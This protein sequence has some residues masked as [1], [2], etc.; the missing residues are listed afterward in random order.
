MAKQRTPDLLKQM[1]EGR[2]EVPVT[3]GKRNLKAYSMRLIEADY[4]HM[5]SFA[6]NQGISI[7]GAIRM[8]IAQFLQKEGLR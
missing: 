8:A 6:E 7:S 3:Q 4:E 1:V 2:N 5:K